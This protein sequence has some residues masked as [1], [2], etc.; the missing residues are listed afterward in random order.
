[1]A[2]PMVD[3]RALLQEYI[4][5]VRDCGGSDY[6]ATGIRGYR[7]DTMFTP[8]A[9]AELERVARGEEGEPNAQ[10]ER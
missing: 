6:I 7:G 3:S 10:R 2:T 8:E 1:M 5:Y 4:R 9:W